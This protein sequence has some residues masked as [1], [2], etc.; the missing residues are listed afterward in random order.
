MCDCDAPQPCDIP[1]EFVRFKYRLPH[2]AQ[3]L[4]GNDKIKIVAIGSSSTAGEGGIPPY[5]CRLEVALRERFPNLT[6]DVL[7]RG[8]NGEEAQDEVKRFDR[9]IL[10]ES[11]LLVI[12][13]V[14]TNAVYH[15]DDPGVVVKAIADGLDRLRGWPMDVVLMDLQYAPAM[16]QYTTTDMAEKM[17]SSIAAV[18]E[19]A[20]VNVFR[21]FALMKHW[22]WDNNVLFNRM[23]DPTDN[24]Q[25]HQSEWSSRCVAQA[26]FRAIEGAATGVA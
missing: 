17:V 3:A 16:L 23:I 20:R 7:N 1:D 25:L 15:R 21:R 13:Q 26:L 9:D 14:G 11:P 12:W 6:I 2:L 10:G 4:K 8:K 19:K 5:P 22:R 18:A 24:S